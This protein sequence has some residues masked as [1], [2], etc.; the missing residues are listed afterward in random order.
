MDTG[1]QIN[2]ISSLMNTRICLYL[3]FY[4]SNQYGKQLDQQT[5]FLFFLPFSLAELYEGSSKVGKS[6]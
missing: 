4:F 5:N 2:K 1:K 3:N 6:L